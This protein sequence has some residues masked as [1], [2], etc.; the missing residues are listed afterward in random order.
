ML[1]LYPSIHSTHD[2]WVALTS[3]EA[4]HYLPHMKESIQ[5]SRL[6]MKHKVLV[7]PQKEVRQ[8]HRLKLFEAE[9]IDGKVPNCTIRC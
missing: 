6:S 1:S 2:D 8:W 3:A 4:A 5:I 9:V 7:H